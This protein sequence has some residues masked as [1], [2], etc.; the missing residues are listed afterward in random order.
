M[1]YY[2]LQAKVRS[3]Y[4]E[5]MR[6]DSDWETVNTDGKTQ[7]SVLEEVWSIVRRAVGDGESAGDIGQLWIEE[8]PHC[9]G[10]SAK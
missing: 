9:N 1:Y 6:D 5:L 4:A 10:N 3:N 7:E 2:V 8:Q